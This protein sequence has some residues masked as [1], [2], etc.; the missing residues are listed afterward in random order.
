MSRQ[1]F[2]VKFSGV[3]ALGEREFTGH[4]SVFGNVDLGGDIVAPGAF[5]ASLAA[6]RKAGT[7][8]VM[9]WQHDVTRVPGKWLSIVEDAKGLAVHGVLAETPLGDEVRELLKLEAVGGLSVGYRTV[10]SDYTRD[11][12]RLLKQLDL[13]EVSVVSMPMNSQATVAAVKRNDVASAV[14]TLRDY[15]TLCRGAYGLS[16][17][18]AKRLAE[19][20]YAAFCDAIGSDPAEA[21]L[22][23][24]AD[25]TDAAVAIAIL[26]A[27][28]ER[29]RSI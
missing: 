10:L 4:G 13:L 23:H 2:E 26:R 12:H 25:E 8:P 3:Q 18:G 9:A 28:A 16:R 27:S 7:W 15:E 24:L 14:R 6:H 21:D 22:K 20:T 1:I 17:A 29:I 11:G 19:R 5:A